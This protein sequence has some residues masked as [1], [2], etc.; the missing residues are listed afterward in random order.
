[1][2]NTSSYELN[3]GNGKR[4]NGNEDSPRK[5]GQMRIDTKIRTLAQVSL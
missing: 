4:P 1:M 5:S 3:S 2:G